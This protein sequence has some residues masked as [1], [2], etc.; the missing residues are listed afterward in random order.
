LA[1]A[2]PE[3]S[4]RHEPEGRNILGD[5]LTVSWTVASG[6]IT[7]TSASAQFRRNIPEYQ[8]NQAHIG[9]VRDSTPTAFPQVKG[10]IV[11]PPV[12]IEPTT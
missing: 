6:A 3:S 5:A 2:N 9:L 7:G 8:R 1:T 11:E 10:A 4:T 12:G